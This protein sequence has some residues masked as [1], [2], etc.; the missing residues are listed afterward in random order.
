MADG[1]ATVVDASLNDLK[2]LLQAGDIVID[3][4]NSYYR[5]D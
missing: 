4:G 1:A 3:G 2:P 5:D